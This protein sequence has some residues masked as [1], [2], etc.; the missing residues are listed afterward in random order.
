MY[1]F[2]FVLQNGSLV[3]LDNVWMCRTLITYQLFKRNMGYGGDDYS[4]TLTI[5]NYRH[6]SLL[7]GRGYESWGRNRQDK[8]KAQWGESGVTVAQ[9]QFV[10]HFVSWIWS[11]PYLAK[12]NSLLAVGHQGQTGH[13]AA[14]HRVC[15]VQWFWTHANQPYEICPVFLF[16]FAVKKP[17]RGECSLL[18]LETSTH[19]WPQPKCVF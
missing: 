7:D 5:Y 18:N 11:N 12:L 8:K 14:L 4:K 9:R 6:A 17:W 10:C 19:K 15:Y 1:T 3:I 2:S 16:G 13:G